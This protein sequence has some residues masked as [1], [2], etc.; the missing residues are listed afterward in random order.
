VTPKGRLRPTLVPTVATVIGVLILGNL[1]AWQL[2]RHAFK[3][4]WVPHARSVEGMPAID[5]SDLVDRDLGALAFR[6]IK[7]RGAFRDDLMLEGGRRMGH[8]PGYAVLQVFETED[9]DL[10]VDRG[11]IPSADRDATLAGLA[12]H[13][14]TTLEGQLRP[15]PDRFDADPVQPV[16]DP[17][18]WPSRSLPGIH[19]HAGDVLKGVY[20]RAGPALEAGQEPAPNPVLADGYRPLEKNYS[21]LHYSKQWAA[22]A[23][24][25]LGMWGWVSWKRDES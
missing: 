24:I 20:L 2:R 13:G 12:G 10:L 17:P 11:E 14:P 23:L 18:V 9:Y 22:M 7:L 21:S 3:N 15:L 5:G 16:S 1:S 4:R 6:H 25:L 19:R 8:V